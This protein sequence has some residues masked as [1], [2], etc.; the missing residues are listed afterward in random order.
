MNQERMRGKRAYWCFRGKFYARA[1]FP[2]GEGSALVLFSAGGNQYWYTFSGGDSIPGSRGGFSGGGKFYA[3]G[4][5]MLQ[6]RS[7]DV[8]L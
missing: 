4:N 5:S 8:M 1:V 7:Q 6:H 2:P 3:G